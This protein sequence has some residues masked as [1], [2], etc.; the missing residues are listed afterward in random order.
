V[1]DAKPG[2]GSIV[3]E[4]VSYTIGATVVVLVVG[5]TFHNW[6]MAIPTVIVASA[7]GI[8]GPGLSRRLQATD[9][10]RQHRRRRRPPSS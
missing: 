4:V 8:A 10:Y 9:W 1:T 3:T 2:R 6:D 5:L 7:G